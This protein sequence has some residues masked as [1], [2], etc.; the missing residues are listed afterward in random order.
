[1]VSLA[2]SFGRLLEEAF[3]L[4]CRS[5]QEVQPNDALQKPRP[6]VIVL[7]RFALHAEHVYY[8]TLQSD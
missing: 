7:S 5:H 1:M 2:E 3:C 4:C 8:A 6:I